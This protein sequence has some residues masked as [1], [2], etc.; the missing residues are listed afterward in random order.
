M[1]LLA[2]SAPG[3]NLTSTIMDLVLPT[4]GVFAADFGTVWP[5]LLA[6][7]L[8]LAILAG[9]SRL[10]SRYLQFTIYFLTGSE[11]M[12]MVIYFLI[13]LPGIFVHEAAHWLMAKLFGL[14]TGKFRVWPER[15]RGYI[16]LGSVQVSSGGVVIDNLVGM[17]PLIAGTLLIAVIGVGVFDTVSLADALQRGRLGTVLRSV[18]DALQT[19]D[20]VLWTYLLFNLGNVMMPS[21]SDRHQLAPLLLYM[22]LA[23]VIY[24]ILDL[25]LD[26][27][28]AGLA[29]LLT[30]IEVITSALIFVIAL[31]LIAV[32]IL[33]LTSNVLGSLRGR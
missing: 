13:F 17:A 14:R 30:P 26:W 20:G 21:A 2:L 18:A 6:L 32:A 22:L 1:L 33:F 9:L 19:S 24:L 8:S 29:N 25:P 7:A 23:G 15:R 27:L 3:I 16:G 11:D 31:D 5:G 4:T 10:L 12:A 28:A